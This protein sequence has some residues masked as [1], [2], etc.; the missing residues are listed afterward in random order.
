MTT[1][2]A[3]SAPV[4]VIHRA[5]MSG[6]YTVESPAGSA[7]I[8][9][10]HT[11]GPRGGRVWAY[12]IET[13]FKGDRVRLHYGYVTFAAAKRGITRLVTNYLSGTAA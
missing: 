9:R 7:V 3:P 13:A 12:E 2:T 5:P 4:I 6:Q 1:T 8:T 10:V 11:E